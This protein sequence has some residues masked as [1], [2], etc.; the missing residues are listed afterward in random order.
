MALEIERKFLVTG[1][2]WR[3][4]SKS[5]QP[6]RQGY[7]CRGPGAVVR[8][9]T[10]G[11]RAFLTIKSPTPGLVRTE[12]EYEIPHDEAEFLLA[13]ACGDAFIEKTRHRIEWDGLDWVIDEF[14]GALTG[15]AMAEIELYAT[16]Q[17]IAIPPW[18]GEEVTDDPTYRNE[19][20]SQLPSCPERPAD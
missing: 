20:L 4:A 11:A 1:D 14:H 5:P 16:D 12:F 13:H 8:V 15:L 19:S 2:T 17:D 6:V 9:R 7:L 3:A 10:L 18:A